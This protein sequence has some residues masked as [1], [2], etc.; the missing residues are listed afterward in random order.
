MSQVEVLGSLERRIDL[1]VPVAAIDAEVETRL[2]RLAK[3]VKVPGF[4][5]G[6]VPISQVSKMHGMGVKQEV[7]GESLQKSFY[8]AVEAQ[9]IKV[10]GMPRF[11]PKEGPADGSEIRFSATFEIYPEVRLGNLSAASLK[12]PVA[13]VEEADVDSTLEILRRQRRE[14]GKVERASRQDDLV[15]FDFRGT[16]DGQPFPGGEAEDFSTVIGEGRMLKDFEDNLAGLSAGESRGFDMTFPADYS[17][18]HLAGKTV[19]FDVTMKEVQ[20]PSLPEID[21]D[22]ARALGIADGDVAKLRAEVKANLEREV[23]RRVE[24]RVKEAAMEVLLSCAELELPKSLVGLEIDRLRK[25][26]LDQLRSRGGNIKEDMISADIFR[27]Q[28]ERRVRLGLI[29]ADLVQKHDLA[30]KPEQVK[31][32]IDEYAQGYEDPQEVVNWY[33]GD[34]QRL[35]ELEALALEDNVVAWVVSQVQASDEPVKFDE[36]MG[37]AA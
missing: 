27:D 31:A 25:Q 4:R 2:K 26:M 37:R 32:L 33:L 14:F 17:A 34:P 29:I 19:H 23:R 18:A 13:T 1:T 10:A 16:L 20:A 35:Q 15:R 9:Q 3:S 21:A 6:K 8:N 30:A 5:P 36:L 22:F 7:L 28:A 24:S 12:R 11:E